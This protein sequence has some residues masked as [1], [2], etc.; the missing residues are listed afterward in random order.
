MQLSARSRYAINALVE[1][2]LHDNYGPI[3]LAEL[4]RKQCVSVSYLEKQF[5][6]LKRNGFVEATRGP[7]GGYSLGSQ[8]AQVSIAEIVS[9]V[10]GT[11]PLVKLPKS[12]ADGQVIPDM[13][14]SIWEGLHSTALAYLRSISL[15]NLAR[16]HERRE[17]CV[18]FSSEVVQRSIRPIQSQLIKTDTGASNIGLALG[19]VW[20]GKS[21]S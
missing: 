8:G 1:L 11:V 18:D 7:G 20:P 6:K 21:I 10:D 3:P 4:S 12:I 5:S 13:T 17:M 15:S 16:D 9:V 19:T 14:Q 2:A